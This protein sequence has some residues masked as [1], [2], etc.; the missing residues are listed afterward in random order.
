M[1]SVDL[2]ARLTRVVATGVPGALGLAARDDEIHV[3]AAGLTDVSTGSLLT[4]EHRFPVG[5]LAKTFVSTVVLQLV[6][7]GLLRLDGSVDEHVPGIRRAAGGV[8]LRQLLNH[9]SGIPDYFV[10]VVSAGLHRE[11]TP[12]ELIALS[13]RSPGGEKGRWA[14]SNTN[15]VILGLVIEAATGGSFEQELARRVI[16][17]LHLTS[18][19]SRADEHATARG[20][21]APSNPIVPSSDPELVDSTEVGTSWGWPA[22]VSSA[23]DVARFL[24]ALLGGELLPTAML[25]AMLATVESDWVESV[26]YG[27]GIEEISSVMGMAQL[28]RETYWGH[29]GLGLGHTVVG[30]ASRDGRR[31]TVVMVNQGMIAD[32]TWQ[33]IAEVVQAALE[34]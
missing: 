24:H 3:A 8:T 7:D 17:P 30:L 16:E 21:L 31:R 23:E 1:K 22:V 11:W 13:S 14:Y 26:R 10:E 20:Y 32:E 25:D 5:S 28:G 29:L 2:L 4:A 12:R 6:A 19:G 15:Y 34:T 27:L 9:T 33:A 18:T